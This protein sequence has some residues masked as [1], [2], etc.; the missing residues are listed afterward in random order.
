MEDNMYGIPWV[1]FPPSCRS[2][3]SSSWPLFT[4]SPKK[5]PSGGRRCFFP[6]R[7]ASSSAPP[8][9]FLYNTRIFPWLPQKQNVLYIILLFHIQQYT[10]IIYTRKKKQPLV[11]VYSLCACSWYIIFME[12]L[13]ITSL[14]FVDDIYVNLSHHEECSWYVPVSLRHLQVFRF[15]I[16]YEYTNFIWCCMRRYI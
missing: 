5:M 10:Y 3:F 14:F 8:I 6:P 11:L 7:R 1:C 15:L 2:I 9:F 12:Y 4:L 13:T 16:M